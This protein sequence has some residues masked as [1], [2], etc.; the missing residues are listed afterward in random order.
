MITFNN[1]KLLNE[2]LTDVVYHFTSVRN[3]ENILKTNRFYANHSLTDDVEIEASKNYLFYFSTT[4][5]KNLKGF[6]NVRIKLD[7]KKLSQKYKAFPVEY[8]WVENKIKNPNSWRTLARGHK[9]KSTKS[10]G[11]KENQF[12]F[13]D[14]IV[15]DKPYIEDAR[16]YIIRID[17]LSD[18]DI[19]A[20]ELQLKYHFREIYGEIHKGK[21]PFFI[22]QK[23][24]FV[25]GVE[26]KSRYDQDKDNSPKDDTKHELVNNN[27]M[28]KFHLDESDYQLISVI[29]E[30]MTDEEIT[31]TFN[32][33]DLNLSK[34]KN[35]QQSNKE[36]LDF[37]NFTDITLWMNQIIRKYN[38][39]EDEEKSIYFLGQLVKDMKK[40]KTKTIFEY[41]KAKYK[42]D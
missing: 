33:K 19:E 17:I 34:V 12:E 28:M 13:E 5:F 1:K 20:F 32:I 6:G 40:M 2:G 42:N 10:R 16:K 4:R 41:V 36:K 29:S 21:I 24:A 35:L 39:R 8:W 18:R 25:W 11:D 30:K 26:S 3:L 15:L 27:L 14:R 22:Y 31:K 37:S 9:L 23:Q 7:G 38:L